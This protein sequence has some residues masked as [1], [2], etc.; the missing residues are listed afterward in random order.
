MLDAKHDA[1]MIA[2]ES[3]WLMYHSV[4]RFPG[5]REAIARELA[6]F[7]DAWYA[8]DDKRW[9]I[10]ARSRKRAK[11]L[12]AGILGADP[13]CVFGSENVTTAFHHFIEAIPSTRLNGKT[14]LIAEDCFPSL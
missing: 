11:E 4:G 7:A 8:L 6:R 1:K 5:Q 9:E 10:A 14:V 12:W 13:A 3:G 2:D